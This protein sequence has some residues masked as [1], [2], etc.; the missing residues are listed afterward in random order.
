MSD[1][2]IRA[3]LEKAE[4]TLKNKSTVRETAKASGCSKSCVH[5]Q[6]TQ[7]LPQINPELAK[8]VRQVLDFNLSERHIRGGEATKQLRSK[9][10]GT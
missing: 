8:E 1:R 3:T 6:L 2:V 9:K 7:T 5:Q 10:Y 4:F